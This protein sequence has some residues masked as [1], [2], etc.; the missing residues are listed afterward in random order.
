MGTIEGQIGN[1]QYVW[2]FMC[3]EFATRNQ[4]EEGKLIVFR[5]IWNSQGVY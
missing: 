3:V 4:R 5:G 1:S 2:Y